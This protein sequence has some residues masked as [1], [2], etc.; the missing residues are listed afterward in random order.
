MLKKSALYVTFTG[1]IKSGFLPED[2]SLTAFCSFVHGPDWI[3]VEGKKEM[4]SQIAS[5]NGK[6]ITWDLP[7]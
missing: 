2:D 6:E 5:S 7:F 1:I 3:K 4:A